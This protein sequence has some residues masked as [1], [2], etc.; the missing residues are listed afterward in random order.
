M[1]YLDQA[2]MYKCSATPVPKSFRFLSLPAHVIQGPREA[3]K[4]IH[5][6]IATI[7][8]TINVAAEQIKSQMIKPHGAWIG[9]VIIDVMLLLIA[10]LIIPLKQLK[11]N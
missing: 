2:I 9:R 11:N 4:K 6:D 10:R 3:G 7:H 1:E 8:I 5:S